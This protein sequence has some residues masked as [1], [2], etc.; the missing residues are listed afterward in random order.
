MTDLSPTAYW[1]A[2]AD[3]VLD[4][5]RLFRQLLAA[6][7]EPGTVQ[8]LDAP[9]P[10][11]D[12]CGAALW[13]SLLALCDPEVKLCFGEGLDSPNLRASLAFHTGAKSTADSRQADFAVIDAAAPFAADDFR[14][15]EPIAPERSTTLLVRVERLDSAPVWRLSGPGIPGER[16]LDIGACHPSLLAALQANSDSFPCGL[17]VFFV[18][19]DR[20]VG[21]PRSTRIEEVR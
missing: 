3:P 18:C 11:E 16:H 15:G 17:D 1:P 5:Q 21:L 2:L 13:G 8:Q 12:G 4:G 14:L 20:V 9:Q 10:P 19:G 7:S 6:L